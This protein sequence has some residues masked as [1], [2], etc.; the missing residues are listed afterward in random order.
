[1]PLLV[2]GWG[3]GRCILLTAPAV[4]ANIRPPKYRVVAPTVWICCK[5]G[6]EPWIWSAG[7]FPQARA[8]ENSC[9]RGENVVL[10]LAPLSES[11]GAWKRCLDFLDVAKQGI[12]GRA[13]VS[14]K[15]RGWWEQIPRAG[16]QSQEDMEL[17]RSSFSRSARGRCGDA[18]SPHWCQPVSQGHPLRRRRRNQCP[19]ESFSS[20]GWFGAIK[21]G[22]N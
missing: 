18:V 17:Q 1:M 22:A 7:W 19:G 4:S 16:K 10:P 20:R 11:V 21:S 12:A 6:L 14:R 13:E 15:G 5:T 9:G 2:T 3:G 8:A